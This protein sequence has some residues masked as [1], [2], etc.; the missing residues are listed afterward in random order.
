[1]IL[2]SSYER[3]NRAADTVPW[4]EQAFWILTGPWANLLRRA[5]ADPVIALVVDE[6]DL[7][8]GLARQ[9]IARGQAEILSLEVPRGRRKLARCLGADETGR[10]QA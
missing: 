9:I 1:M 4:E 5:Q 10:D 3:S 2:T 6:C 8:T 7:A